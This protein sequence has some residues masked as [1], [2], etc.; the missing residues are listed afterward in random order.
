MAT[1]PTPIPVHED[2]VLNNR[3][4]QALV[5]YFTNIIRDIFNASTENI[6]DVGQGNIQLEAGN[7]LILADATDGEIN[8]TLPSPKFEFLLHK[9]LLK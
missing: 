3:P 6:V 7:Q 2:I 1:K 4:T 8:I 9:G 5:R